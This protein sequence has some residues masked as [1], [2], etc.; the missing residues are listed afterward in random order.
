MIETDIFQIRNPNI[1]KVLNSY[2][3]ILFVQI[4]Y[5]RKEMCRSTVLIS[6]ILPL[7]SGDW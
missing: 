7:L 4:T 6:L 2:G 5:M 1:L 3:R